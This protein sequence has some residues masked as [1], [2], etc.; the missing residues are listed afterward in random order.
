MSDCTTVNVNEGCTYSD[1]D[2]YDATATIDDGSCTFEI[3]ACPGDLNG[4]SVIGT[5]DLLQFLSL[6]GSSCE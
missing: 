3:N 1:A 5:P 4:D 2:N 6:F